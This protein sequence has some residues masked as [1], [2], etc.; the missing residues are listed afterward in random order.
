MKVTQY[1][2]KKHSLSNLCSAHR[3]CQNMAAAAAAAA[4]RRLLII[5]SPVDNKSCVMARAHKW[6][7]TEGTARGGSR[8]QGNHK[9]SRR[10][11]LRR[12]HRQ[13][14]AARRLP[15]QPPVGD[16]AA[17]D[18]RHRARRVTS[19]EQSQGQPPRPRAPPPGPQ[20]P[21]PRPRSGAIVTTTFWLRSWGMP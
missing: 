14:A 12:H 15:I 10:D 2:T 5:E 7:V 19:A 16:E 21:P 13:A 20:Q 6:R 3:H 4:A 11:Q 8:A 18:G 17:C 9:G 1:H